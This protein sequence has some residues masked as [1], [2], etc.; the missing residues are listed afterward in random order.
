MN[1]TVLESTWRELAQLLVDDI[2]AAGKMRTPEWR[3]AVENVPRH[4]FIPRYYT[5]KQ[6]GRSRNWILQEPANSDSITRWLKLVYSRTTLVTQVADFADRGTQAAVSSSTKPDL[7]IRMLEA[8]DVADGMRVLEIGTGYNAALLSHRLG[9]ENVYPV[10]VD[11]HLV[12]NARDRLHRLGYAAATLAV[13]DG[14]EG[15]PDH[16]PY[17]RIIATCALFAV[18]A[19]W[20]TQLRP[21]GLALVH[22]E[23]PL[24]AG[25]LLALRHVALDA[26]AALPAPP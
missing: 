17:D 11:P 2:S 6:N 14:I 20:I 25:N 7:M 26:P 18:P 21:D 12:D 16:A 1:I 13:V 9:A 19:P 15:L 4:L 3:A 10:D 22:I 5:D 24:G 23:G 8:L